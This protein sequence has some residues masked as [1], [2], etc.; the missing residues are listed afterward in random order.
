MLECE[1]TSFTMG[2]YN[3]ILKP[4]RSEQVRKNLRQ[5]LNDYKNVG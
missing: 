3:L 2:I 1:I 5:I 4:R